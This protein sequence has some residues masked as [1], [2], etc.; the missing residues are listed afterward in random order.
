M[1]RDRVALV[2]AAAVSAIVCV[3]GAI[4]QVVPMTLEVSGVI[5]SVDNSVYPG[6]SV[7]NTYTLEYDL[8]LNTPGP[9][10]GTNNEYLAFG[11][12]TLTIEGQVPMIESGSC[13]ITYQNNVVDGLDSI[14]FRSEGAGSSSRY[15][16]FYTDYAGD[17]VLSDA[18]R[19]S[20]INNAPVVHQSSNPFAYRE[21]SPNP[22]SISANMTSFSATGGA[23]PP[24]PVITDEPAGDIVDTGDVVTFT[25]GVFG[26]QVLYQWRRN[27][28]DLTDGP[29]IAGANTS[30]LAITADNSARFDCVVSNPGG[31]D[32]SNEAILAVVNTCPADQNNDGMLSPTDF[33]AWINNY[34]IGCP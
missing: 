20:L 11:E 16:R 12:V 28:I 3:S 31:S 5:N 29:G 17:L 33:T 23:T 1:F 27:G 7:G 24:P 30:K 15:V 26:E 19:A 34:N 14:T 10:P 22:T 13:W 4:G 2:V 21:L 32:T 8:M 25:V 18:P 9:Y 6:V